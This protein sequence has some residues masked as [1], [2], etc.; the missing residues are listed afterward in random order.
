MTT[1]NMPMQGDAV[2]CADDEPLGL[3]DA[4]E[5]MHLRIRRPHERPA[6]VWVPTRA[7]G[8]CGDGIIRLLLNRD[9]LHDGV[10]ALPPARQREYSTLESLSLLLQRQHAPNSSG[11][12]PN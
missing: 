4:I 11:G 3:V 10:I 9:Q 6:I 1:P 2:V 5:G 8:S 12:S 7:I